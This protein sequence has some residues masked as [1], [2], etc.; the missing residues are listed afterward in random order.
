MPQTLDHPSHGFLRHHPILN[1]VDVVLQF[2]QVAIEFVRD[3]TVVVML[4]LTPWWINEALN[5]PIELFPGPL[6][7]SISR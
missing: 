1:L 2:V 3:I 7:H 6:L 4:M 5:A